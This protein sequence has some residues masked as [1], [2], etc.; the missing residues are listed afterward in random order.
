MPM[1]FEKQKWSPVNPSV[2]V[3]EQFGLK[4]VHKDEQLHYNLLKLAIILLSH[5]VSF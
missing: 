3:K 4:L 5:C 2:N 1:C